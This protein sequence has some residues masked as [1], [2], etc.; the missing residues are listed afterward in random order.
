MKNHSSHK[1][2]A[3]SGISRSLC[4][5]LL[6][7]VF[8]CWHARADDAQFTQNMDG[9][10]DVSFQVPLANYP[11]RGVNL[12]I[13]LNY[14]SAGLWRIGF[15]QA[16]PMGSSVWRSVTEGIYAEHSTAGWTTTLDVPK[17][18]WPKQNDIFWYTGKPYPRGTVHPYTFRIARLYMH[19]PGGGVI[20]MRKADAVYQD[21]GIID[22]FGTFYS[23]DGSRMRYDSNGQNSGTLYLP[24]GARYFLGGNPVQYIDVNGNTLNFNTDTREW[25]DTMGRVVGMPWPVNPGPGDY[26][27]LLPGIN[28]TDIPYTLRFKPLSNA[29]TPDAQGQF[30]TLRTMSDYFLPDPGSAP[31][32]PSGGNHPQAAT[33]PTLFI[34]GYTDP[35][36]TSQSFVYVVGRGQAGSNVFN[37]T[38]LA[39]II[40]PNG[41]SYKF[42][43]NIR[44]ELTK[45][46]Y[47]TGG[48]QRYSYGTVAST[49]FLQ[50]PYFQG[51]RGIATRAIS[52]NGTGSDEALWTYSSG[53]SP[54]TVTAPDGTVTENYLFIGPNLTETFGYTDARNGLLQEQRVFAPGGA[55]LRRTLIEYGVTTSITNKPV[56]PNTFNTGTYT[57]YRNPRLQKTVNIMLD[58]GGAALAKTFTYEYN[59][60]N[61]VQYQFTTGRDRT[62]S[63]ETHFAEV[64]PTLAQTGSISSIPAGPT[65]TRAET[66]YLNNSAYQN[67]NILG[68]ATD[69]SIKG[70]ISGSLQ[71]VSQTQT[72]FDEFAS[73]PL[74]TYGD[75]TNYT[76]PGS[77]TVRGNV[78]TTRR[79]VN[80]GAGVSLTSHAQFDQCGNLRFAWNARGIP[81]EKEYASAYNHAFVTKETTAVP[82]SSGVNGSNTAIVLSGTFDKWTGLP[83]TAVDANGQTTTYSYKDDQGNDD[84]L[85]RLRKVTR[86]DGSWTKYSFGETAGNLFTL[87]ESRLDATRTQKSYN[88]L[89]PLGRTSRTFFSEG[90]N[91]YI[92][93]DAIYDQMGRVS[94]VSNPYRTTELDGVAD[95]N[96]TSNWTVSAFDSLGRVT[97]ITLPDASV[98]Q[99]SYQGVY[100]T[101]TDQAGRQRRQKTDALG[102]IVR[103]DEPDASGSI[104]TVDA[105][106]QPTSYQYDTQGNVV[107]IVQGSSPVQHRYFKYDSLGRLLFER[108]VEQQAVFTQFDPVTGNSGWSRKLVYDETIGLDTYSGLLTTTYDARNVE[109]QF[110]YDKLNRIYQVSHSDGTPT[111]TNKYDEARTGY[112]NKGMVTSALTAATSSAPATAQIYNYNAMAR[113]VNHEQTVGAY[114]YSMDYDY[115]FAGVLTSQKYPSGR[116]VN[117]SFDDGARLSQVSSGPTTYAN[118]FDYTSPTGALK[119]LTLG[120]QAVESYTYNSRLQIQSRDLTKGGV[121]LQHYDYKYGVYNPGTNTLD[122]TRNT[123][124]IAQIEGFISSQ[125]Q[126]QQRFTYDSIGRLAS[127]REFRGDNSQQSYLVN[128]DYDV[129]GNRYQKQ[130]QNSGNPFT[131]VWVETS[132]VDQA[133]NRFSTG[134]TYDA[135]GN[136]T[137]DSKFRNRKYAYD[138]NN[139]QKQS[140]NLDDSN[141]VDSVYDANGQR[142]G[143]QVGGELTNVLVYDAQAKLVAEYNPAPVLGGTQ[144]LFQDHQGTPRTIMNSQGVVIARN[145]YLPF[146]DDVLNN[147]GMRA[148]VAEYSGNES[149]RQKYAGMEIDEATGMSHTLWRKYDSFSGRWTAPDPYTGSM[150]LADPQSLNRY[151]YV[152]NNPVNAVDPLGLKL[153]D[154]IDAEQRHDGLIRQGQALTAF[155]DAFARGDLDA[156]RAILN[157]NPSIGYESAAEENPNEGME[158]SES[159]NEDL[160]QSDSHS[161]EGDIEVEAESGAAE[162][163]T[164]TESEEAEAEPQGGGMNDNVMVAGESDPEYNCMAWG[165]GVRTQWIQ[166]GKD[167]GTIEYGDHQGGLRAEREDYTW[168]QQKVSSNAVTPANLPLFFGGEK[169]EPNKA[170]PRD[171]ARIRI[172]EDSANKGNWHVERK[173]AGSSTWTSKNGAGRLYSNI[174]NPDR[175][176]RSSYSPRGLVITTDYCIR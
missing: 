130:A 76:D 86:P 33:G 58:T 69:I 77:A 23:V 46:V 98:V 114:T 54:M 143:T 19:M 124:Q 65:A 79:F 166:P 102:R 30:P 144:Y 157:A 164:S 170:C 158:E 31:T 55:M 106:T 39:E 62:A 129:F 4:V 149:A 137:I 92:A 68:L 138:A 113:V 140:K 103:V 132:H 21:T 35:E 167:T 121:Q 53:N 26:Q 47:P 135:A 41:Q 66:I 36:E 168:K 109:V 110:R 90:G 91:S 59:Q 57:A 52:A 20:E 22:M 51:S 141:P 8:T 163:D 136:V 100:T 83:L 119:S 151:T 48:Y 27:W 14:S 42:T 159:H 45:V 73:Y 99:T 171:M 87:A 154:I 101:I 12:P 29:L 145:D 139:R 165:L 70:I 89:D 72:F 123:G 84:P 94:K 6:L 85:N 64:D 162:T 174:N 75:L 176:Y 13:T 133:T 43:Y 173:E 126:W 80:P 116:V 9:R 93:S 49:G 61:Q 1:K 81:S 96:H 122:E 16:V 40:L 25:T 131:Q 134:A 88:Y 156:C 15:I 115:N 112:H 120:N 118:Q 172:Y 117:Y 107:H 3:F 7:I 155:N 146:G 63:V 60:S 78:T 105:P 11:G 10:H 38:V 56:P 2:S 142:V 111:I 34:S 17:V 152:N 5:S 74:L 67:R 37:P 127:A 24:N 18:E 50:F 32:G 125:K 175:F 150:T 148:S 82:D 108:Q 147:V 104:G 160:G 161:D 169:V 128:Y 71:V 44:G 97:S 153:Q 28:D 95:L